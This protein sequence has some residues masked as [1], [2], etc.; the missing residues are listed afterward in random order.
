MN[1]RFAIFTF[2]TAI[3]VVAACSSTAAAPAEPTAAQTEAPAVVVATP[4]VVVAT[5]VP[6]TATPEATA[7]PA[8]APG[9]V[10][11][12]RAIKVTMDNFSFEPAAVTVG[13]GETI[14][15]IVSNPTTIPHEFVLGDAEEQEH[16]HMEMAEGM[17]DDHMMDEPNEL[18]LEAGETGELVW[19]FD[20][21]GE[22]MMGC[23]IEGHWEA[24]ML[25]NISVGS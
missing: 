18:E 25:G 21:A 19:T 10:D 20:E 17:S 12:P 15:F 8:P 9:T 6:P 23:H 16:H 1:K 4:A 13:A 24:G 3:L 11:A 22:Q 5:P 2:G 14:R 7:S